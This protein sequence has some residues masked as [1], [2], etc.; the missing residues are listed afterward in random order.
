M[1]ARTSKTM[2]NSQIS[3]SKQQYQCKLCGKFHDGPP[4][5]YGAPAPAMW[6]SIPES[7][8]RR[9]NVLS[10]DNCIINGEFFF[11]VGNINIP[12]IGTT[13]IFNWSVWVSLSKE[14]YQRAEKLWNKRGREKEPPYF[15]WLNTQLSPY[16]DTLNLKTLVH[17]RSVGQRPLVELEPTEH[18]LSV[19]QRTGIT[20]QRVQE[21]AEIIMHV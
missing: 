16:P 20:W 18:P 13:D 14:N 17:T 4:L 9:D 8:Q 1:L 3:G 12:V 19:E 6:Y 2:P 21:L 15:G 5:S 10:R 11:I 7:E